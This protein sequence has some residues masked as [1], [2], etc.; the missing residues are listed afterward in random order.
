MNDSQRKIVDGIISL[1]EGLLEEA[2]ATSEFCEGADDFGESVVNG[3]LT[4]AHGL[5]ELTQ[6]NYYHIFFPNEK[7]HDLTEKYESTKYRLTQK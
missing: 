3:L 1:V 7:Y 6:T 2:M 4:E 5:I